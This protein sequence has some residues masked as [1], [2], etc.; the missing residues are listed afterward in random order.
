MKLPPEDLNPSHYPP[1]FTNTYTCGVT[2]A[3]RMYGGPIVIARK[4]KKKKEKEG[5]LSNVV[6][7]VK[8][9]N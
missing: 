6:Y 3:P 2:I 4:K 9:Y 7:G 5:Y 1:H 8:F